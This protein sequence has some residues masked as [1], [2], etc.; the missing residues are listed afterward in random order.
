MEHVCVCNNMHLGYSPSDF[1]KV[2]GRIFCGSLYAIVPESERFGKS[3]SKMWGMRSVCCHLL[4]P[5][6]APVS[7]WSQL[8]M[9]T[10]APGQRAN[11]V[12]DMATQQRSR[13]VFSPTHV[14]RADRADEADALTHVKEPE[15]REFCH[16]TA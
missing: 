13:P 7:Q 16:P 2:C 1:D 11:P 15:G 8:N 5:P 14:T 6:H 4:G 12:S 3:D 10:S 9:D